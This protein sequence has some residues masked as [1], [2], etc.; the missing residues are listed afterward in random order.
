MKKLFT[1][2][3][4][5][6]VFLF[7]GTVSAQTQAKIE[8]TEYDMDNGLHVIL[9]QDHSS[10]N[11]MVALMYHVGAKNEAPDKTGFAHFFEHLMFEGSQNR[12]M[13]EH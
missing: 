6:T 2:L 12:Q 10:P 3:T 8:Y 4:L 7:A 5:A 11:V 9:H 1:L 13:V